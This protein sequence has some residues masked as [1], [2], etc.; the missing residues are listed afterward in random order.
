MLCTR[1]L[2]PSWEGTHKGTGIGITTSYCEAQAFWNQKG[3]DE[4]ASPWGCKQRTRMLTGHANSITQV[5]LG[6]ESH[7]RWGLKPSPYEQKA[8]SKWVWN[9][10]EPRH[11]WWWMVITR[12]HSNPHQQAPQSPVHLP[13]L[14]PPLQLL[15][16][17]QRGSTC[18]T[19]RPWH[20]VPIFM[21]TSVPA[22]MLTMLL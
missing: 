11:P 20:L 14:S 15:W 12:Q 1:I 5:D 10:F 18:Q 2:L 19:F 6:W 16:F 9:N 13:T 8:S 7:S 22:F 17:I 4:S 21:L 3:R